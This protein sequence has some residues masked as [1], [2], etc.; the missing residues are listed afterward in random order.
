MVTVVSKPGAP[1]RGEAGKEARIDFPIGKAVGL[2]LAFG[3][4]LAARFGPALPGLSA[5]GQVILGVFLWFVICLAT[6]ALPQAVVGV[7]APLFAVVLGGVPIPMA[8]GAF[9]GDVFFLA[10]GAFVLVAAMIGSGLGKR[11]AFGIVAFVR[12]TRASR[13]LGSLMGAGTLLHA[14]L[15]TV[16]ETALFLPISRCLGEISDGQRSRPLDRAHSATVL[17]VAGLVPLFAGVFFLTAG[18]PNLVLT[19]LL[20]SSY[21]IEVTWLDWLVF[22]LPL[23]GL[24]PILFFIIRRWFRMSEVE[25]PNA[26]TRLPQ[27]RAELGPFSRPEIWTLVTVAVGFVLWVTEPLHHISTGMVSVIMALLL[28]APWT[29]ISFQQHGKH[30][31]WQVLFLIGGAISMGDLLYKTGGVTWLADFLVGPITRSGLHHPVLVVLVLAFALHIARAGVL[32]GGAMAA[33]FVPLAIALAPALDLSVLP[34][35]LILVN[36][37]NFAIFVPISAVAVLV[38]FE[39]SGLKWG[40]MMRLG[41]LISIVANVYLVLTQSLWMDL[42][43]YPLR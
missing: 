21:G 3:V 23:W 2:L 35:S 17:T 20:K 10:F 19:G 29:G 30:M 34:F 6:D 22:N 40:E 43:G 9:S 31:M 11:I 42:L 16:S 27:M 39:A 8:F 25:V 7:G 32:S 33:A 24:I 28:L 1:I 15:P 18:V 41:A 38:A 5:E 26:T 37:L 14:V 13:I 4:M 36:A 12:S